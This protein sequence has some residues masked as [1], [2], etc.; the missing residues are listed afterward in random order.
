MAYFLPRRWR[1][2]PAG[3]WHVDPS[4]PLARDLLYCFDVRNAIEVLSQ[5]RLVATGTRPTMVGSLGEST[6]PWRGQLPALSRGF[7]LTYGNG[8]TD[9]LTFVQPPDMLGELTIGWSCTHF[10]SELGGGFGRILDIP[11]TAGTSLRVY[12][13]GSNFF[14]IDRPYTGGD[15]TFAPGTTNISG[16]EQS[17]HVNIAAFD[18]NTVSTSWRWIADGNSISF[19]GG[20]STGTPSPF[21]G[22][23]VIGNRADQARNWAGGI[24]MLCIWLR[25]FTESECIEWSNFRYAI[26]TPVHPTLY[27]L[28]RP[29]AGNTL[30]APLGT[31]TLSGLASSFTQGNALTAPLGQLTLSGLAASFAQTSGNTLAAPLG[32]LT[33][34]GLAPSF[35][36]GNTL[37]APL[38]QLTLAGFDVSFVQA[39][40]NV[41]VAPLGQMTLVGF[42]ASF[43]S[44]GLPI[45][46]GQP[47]AQGGGGGRRLGREVEELEY[48][49]EIE[50]K[51][52]DGRT[53]RQAIADLKQVPPL[54]KQVAKVEKKALRQD[55]AA[56]RFLAEQL[57]SIEAKAT[58]SEPGIE[59]LIPAVIE[60]ILE[61][62]RQVL[63]K[64]Q[65]IVDKMD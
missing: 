22:P 51:L 2:Q 61:E 58:I 48:V 34:S 5:R 30:V 1:R 3:P 42:D 54:R 9:A 43:I 50:R 11:T 27:F 15:G 64:L 55:P 35:S 8:S 28:G 44:G 21:N 57:R 36:Q 31:L 33:L 63:A 60:F 20:A 38:G 39:G 32:Q 26:L 41:L 6:Q 49:K 59:E 53:L 12:D 10:L 24:E 40:A 16:N 7:G 4:H 46:G 56:I 52:K 18:T 62:E 23:L 37:T 25:K 13:Q 47:F 45:S 65:T 29:A 17:M 19:A 14:E